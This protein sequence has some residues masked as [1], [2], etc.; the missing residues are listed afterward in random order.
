MLDGDLNELLQGL[1]AYHRTR[2]LAQA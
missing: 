1:I 2:A